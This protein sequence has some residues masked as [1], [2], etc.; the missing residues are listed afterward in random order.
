MSYTMTLSTDTISILKSFSGIQSNI[1]FTGGNTI[2]TLAETKTI[3]ASAEVSE[4]FPE[5]MIG[6]FDLPEF[7]GVLS[8]FDEPTL[9]FDEDGNYVDV[10]SGGEQSVRYYLSNPSMLT[11]PQ[12]SIELPSVDM[13]FV[14]SKEDLTSIRKAS[15]VLSAPDMV[16][17]GNAGEDEISIAVTDIEN[18]TSNTFNVDVPESKCSKETDA[19]FSLVFKVQNL[20]KLIGSQSY[21]VSV[22]KKKFSHF[23]S[24]GSDLDIQYWVA[25]YKESSFSNDDNS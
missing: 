5:M 23:K 24:R 20:N 6:V 9:R 2:S 11:Y 10:T 7:L 13:S 19:S 12:K 15:S 25:L 17:T 21:D 1:V 4:T 8:M 18:P 22:S 16:V 3:L 14:L